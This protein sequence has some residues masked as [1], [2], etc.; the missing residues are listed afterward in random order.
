MAGKSK[1]LIIE[2]EEVLCKALK[3]IL[4]GDY[5]V[6]IAFNGKEGIEKI[7]KEEPDVILL[8]IF[9]P[10]MNGLDIL[11]IVRKGKDT[12]EIPVIIL[13]NCGGRKNVEKGLDMG[14]N[15]YFIKADTDLTDVLAA[16]KEV[17][18]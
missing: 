5:E 12:K 4:E 10:N 7:E 16:V 17:L 18:S 9:L 6:I 8:D 11:E 14:A 15:K 13:S 3:S 2:D 1:I